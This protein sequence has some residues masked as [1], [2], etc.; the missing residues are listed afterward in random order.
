MDRTHLIASFCAL[1]A[2]ATPAAHA[3]RAV[4][5]PAA[6]DTAASHS[7][8]QSPVPPPKATPEIRRILDAMSRASTSGHPDLF[9]QFAGM[10][11]LFEGDYRSALKY[12]KNAAL[13]ADKPSQ[14]SIGL[15]YLNGRGVKKDPVTAC[16]WLMLAAER[17]VPQQYIMVRDRVCGALSSAQHEQAMATLDKLS[18][19]YADATAKLKMKLA[20]RTARLAFTGSRVGY[21]FNVQVK[22]PPNMVRR[23]NNDAL[24]IGGVYVPMEGCG[25]YDPK[26]LDSG[27]YFAARDQPP[28]GTV[29]IG[30]LRQVDP[31]VSDTGT[32]PKK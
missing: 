25:T 7:T 14:M 28:Q 26:L 29:T 23:C 19:R 18:P 9:G 2:C 11:H 5:G 31:P 15:M 17:G 12:F 4:D 32:K 16:A 10:R 3:S 21:D 8:T 27:K 6:K 22:A 13:Y 1:L 24:Y 20:L 30:T